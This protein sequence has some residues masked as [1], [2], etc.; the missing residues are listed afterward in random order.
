MSSGASLMEA[1]IIW[2]ITII[3]AF[4]LAFGVAMPW[5]I[6]LS[7]FQTAGF[8][9]VGSAWNTSGDRTTLGNLILVC[10]YI[11]PIL[12]CINFFATAVRR[13]QYDQESIYGGR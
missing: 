10:I 13:Q 5:D 8:D 7:I 1:F 4:A 9:N 3:L 2:I 12:G 11:L 6:L